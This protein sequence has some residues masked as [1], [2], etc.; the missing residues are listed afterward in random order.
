M[1]T[2]HFPIIGRYQEA[3]ESIAAPKLPEHIDSIGRFHCLALLV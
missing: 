1:P 3:T 2:R